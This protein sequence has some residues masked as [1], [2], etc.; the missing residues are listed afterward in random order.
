MKSVFAIVQ[1][2]LPEKMSD[3]G[4]FTIPC[5]FVSSTNQRELADLGTNISLMPYS[6]FTQLEQGE[7]TPTQM[8]I[9][10]VDK[11]VKNPWGVV[12]NML[13]RI[14]KFVFP[15]DFVT[16]DM[17]EDE[18]VPLVLGHA[19]LKTARGLIDVSA[20]IITLRVSEKK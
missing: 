13:V 3:P 2:M 8:S 1:N 7:L 5:L 9:Q 10:L 11:S 19:F 6:I 15:L 17:E 4:S 20:G 14:Y 12:E 16:L 18:R